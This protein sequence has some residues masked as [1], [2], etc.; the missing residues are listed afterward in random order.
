MENRTST[1]LLQR[2]I[3]SQGEN[4][5]G[6]GSSAGFSLKNYE[7]QV[8]VTAPSRFERETISHC[9]MQGSSYRT[10]VSCDLVCSQ[11]LV[12]SQNWWASVRCR[13]L[14]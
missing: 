8:M 14:D 6:F 1:V 10:Q 7:L 4:K 2:R 13:K 3:L 5:T 12:G 11:G 9:Q